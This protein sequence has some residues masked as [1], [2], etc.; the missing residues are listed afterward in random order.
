MSH[1]IT[2]I[3]QRERER[4]RDFFGLLINSLT[5]TGLSSKVYPVL[6]FVQF[7]RIWYMWALKM[8]R[9]QFQGLISSMLSWPSWTSSV[10]AQL[11]L[12][13]ISRIHWCICHMWLLP[14]P[15]HSCMA[16][17]GAASDVSLQQCSHLCLP[18]F[19]LLAT[20]GRVVKLSCPNF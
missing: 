2:K 3:R 17:A 15:I 19:H 20:G 7:K 11:F 1:T 6:C 8:P 4:E 10:T 13:T 14:Q 16:Q 12:G 9:K 5:I 18:S